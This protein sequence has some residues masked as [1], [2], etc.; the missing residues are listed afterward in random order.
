MDFYGEVMDFYG[1]RVS[2]YLNER[3]PA[4]DVYVAVGTVDAFGMLIGAVGL[5]LGFGL[6]FLSSG[7]HAEGGTRTMIFVAVGVA[8]GVGLL[9]WGA[10]AHAA[11]GIAYLGRRTY[12]SERLGAV[13]RAL[14][15]HPFRFTV[16]I[17]LATVPGM[18]AILHWSDSWPN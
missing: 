4:R 11:V 13:G 17:A 14:L 7:L 1:E 2:A 15:L 16:A 8:P 6:A 3:G 9:F 10:L 18:I 5:A 12:D